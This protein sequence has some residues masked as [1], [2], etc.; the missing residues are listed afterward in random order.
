MFKIALHLVD[1]YFEPFEKDEHL[2]CVGL[3]AEDLLVLVIDCLL[4]DVADETKV[5]LDPM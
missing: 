4:S 2:F 5:L 3:E 1:M